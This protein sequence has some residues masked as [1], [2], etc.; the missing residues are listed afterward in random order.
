MRSVKA[1]G[2]SRVTMN[3]I[4][5]Y[6]NSHKEPGVETLV[7]ILNILWWVYGLGHVKRG[8]SSFSLLMCNEDS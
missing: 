2:K 8:F 4:C 1:R 6:P 3:F 5:L 7:E